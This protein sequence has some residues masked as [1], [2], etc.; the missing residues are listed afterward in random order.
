VAIEGARARAGHV[1]EVP[2]SFEAVATPAGVLYRRLVRYGA[3]HPVGRGAIGPAARA[4]A[5]G[6]SRLALDPSLARLD[7]ASFLYLD[8]ETTGLA[9]GTGTI[10]FLIGL[11]SF[12]GQGWVLEQLLVPQPGDEEP[13]LAR[14]AAAIEAAGCVVTYNGKSFDLPLLRARFAL[15]R[16]PPLAARPHLDLMH[17]ARRLHGARLGRCP[18]RAI[19]GEVLGFER[20]TTIT[21]AEVVGRYRA[22]LRSGEGALLDEVVEHNAADIL[23]LVALVALYDDP[24]VMLCPQDRVALARIW[25]RAGAPAEALSALDGA[26]LQGAGPELFRARADA[27]LQLGDEARAAEALAALLAERDE[28]GTRLRL[29]KLYEHGLGRPAEALRLVEQGTGEGPPALE[30]RRRRLA[31]KAARPA[32]PAL[33]GFEALLEPAARRPRA[34]R[35]ASSVLALR[36]G[37]QGRNLRLDRL[38]LADGE[39]DLRLAQPPRGVDEIE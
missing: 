6:L 37:E 39:L 20:P 25:S 21:S 34:R 22:F 17:V 31:R 28:G 27:A 33:P 7:A 29:A 26:A 2:T 8:T 3:S 19:E 35:G 16:L 1:L 15:N 14:A 4:C 11:A 36:E 30:R 32:Q 24:L 5:A 38:E 18:L 23:S 13:A 10:A 9:G 12:D